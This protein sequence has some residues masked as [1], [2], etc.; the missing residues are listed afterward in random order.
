MLPVG[1]APCNAL[2]GVVLEHVSN[3]HTYGI[4]EKVIS[5]NIVLQKETETDG[6]TSEHI[7]HSMTSSYD[8]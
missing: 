6:N 2:I 4:I 5:S 7:S 1:K 3:L 8:R